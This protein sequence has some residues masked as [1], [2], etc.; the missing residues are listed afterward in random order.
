MVDVKEKAEEAWLCLR[1]THLGLNSVGIQGE[2]GAHSPASAITEQQQL[3]QCNNSAQRSGLQ[4][5]MGVNHALMLNP[6]IQLTERD[7]NKEAQKLKELSHWAYRFTSQ[8]S[9]H[10]HSSLLLEIGRSIKLFKGLKHLINLINHDLERF[11]IDTQLGI[12][13]TPKAAF[14]LSFTPIT[15]EHCTEQAL[16]NTLSRLLASH[17]SSLEVDSK[18]IQQL[19]HCGFEQLEELEKIP[20]A[21]LGRRFGK[22]FLHYLDQ[23]WGRIADPQLSTTPPETFESSADFAE[24][25]RNLNWINQQLD[26]LLTDLEHFISARQLICR[27]FTWRFYHENNRLLHTVS[28]GLSSK[29]NNLKT[30]RELSDLKLASIQLQWEFASIELSSSQLVPRQLFNDDLFDPQPSQEQFNQLIDKLTNRLGDHA[31]FRVHHAPEHLPELANGRQNA[32]QEENSKYSSHIATHSTEPEQAFKDQPL[33]LLE[34]P[35]RLPQN[36]AKYKSEP[37]FQGPLTIIHGPDRITSH[38]WSKI[39][40]R[41]YFIARQKNGRLLWLFFDR[42]TRSWFLHG[43]FA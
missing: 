20:V 2:C 41:D 35:Q 33:W 25:I 29:Q 10:N 27:S 18:T 37:L 32:V 28:I 19:R 21:E 17:L 14:V 24:P 40:S 11:Q 9:I 12:G 1:F 36:R 23:L 16:Q 13:H 6:T 30:F 4:A 15:S 7:K 3:Y 22:D 5:G 31:L 38:W 8:V 39:Q 43:L 34:S 42:D 26:R